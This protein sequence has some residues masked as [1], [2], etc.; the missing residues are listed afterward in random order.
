MASRQMVGTRK[1]PPT[2]GNDE[3]VADAGPSDGESA[4]DSD[5]V[6]CPNCACQFDERTGDVVK[7]GAK[8]EG[9]PVKPGYEGA[10]LDASGSAEPVP[11]KLGTAHDA[12]MG[13]AVMAALLSG[14]HGGPGVPRVR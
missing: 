3:R 14:A 11:G 10:D 8:V 5:V 2:P 6:E 13:D 7:D 1:G 9:G 12:S 4:D